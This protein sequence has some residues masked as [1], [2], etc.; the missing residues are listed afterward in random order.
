M[1][2]RYAALLD[3]HIQSISEWKS[4]IIHVVHHLLLTV[5]HAKGY[6][7]PY[8]NGQPIQWLIDHLIHIIRET[9]LIKKITE[10]A[11][12]PETLLI[13]SILRTLVEF[14]HE[15]DLL[16]YIKQLKITPILHSLISLPYESIAIHAYVVLAY[17][18]EEDDIKASE[19]DSGRLLSNIFDTLRKK[20]QKRSKSTT[21]QEINERNVSLLTEAVQGNKIL[22]SSLFFK[23][24]LFKIKSSCS[25]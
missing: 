7:T 14:V 3:K 4:P 19:K 12:T 22:N 25:T 10:K 8:A 18:L 16:F 9:S 1:I 15:P 6:Y 13:N 20:I 2:P 5:N 17:T 23:L 24:F 21:N 11:T